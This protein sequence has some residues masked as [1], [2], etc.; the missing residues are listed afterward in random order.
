MTN[1]TEHT[2]S[3]PSAVLAIITGVVSRLD[4]YR[5]RRRYAPTIRHLRQLEPYL[6]KDIGV[7]ERALYSSLPTIV[8]KEQVTFH[9]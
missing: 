4:V 3:R 8:S 2:S 6:L 5:G 7:D 9:P 1:I